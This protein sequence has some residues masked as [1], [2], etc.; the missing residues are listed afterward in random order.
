MRE[1]VPPW[2]CN[3]FGQ[4]G[5][6]VHPW[7]SSSAAAS[8]SSKLAII[9]T[10]T[11]L[12]LGLMGTSFALAAAF[13]VRVSLA[14]GRSR[15]HGV[16][17]A[18]LAQNENHFTQV[19]DWPCAKSLRKMI[20]RK[21]KKVLQI[22]SNFGKPLIKYFS[23][24]LILGEGELALARKNPLRKTVSPSLHS[25]IRQPCGPQ[26]CISLFPVFTKFYQHLNI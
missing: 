11:A 26:P 9:T 17:C 13:F 15:W 10:T 24:T 5:T 22:A 6:F 14:H 3:L 19:L 7:A 18:I 4:L 25:M 23:V 2:Q 1:P 16:S 20:L 8:A 12:L 21:E